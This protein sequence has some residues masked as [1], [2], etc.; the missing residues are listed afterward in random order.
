MCGAGGGSAHCLGVWVLG[1]G[2]SRLK[3]THLHRRA[4]VIF[5]LPD[6]LLSFPTSVMGPPTLASWAEWGEVAFRVY[7]VLLWARRPQ[8]YKPC[9]L[10]VALGR[11]L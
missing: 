6:S 1:P 11:T 5:C 8:D 4:E 9:Q 10:L 3:S 2:R 7:D